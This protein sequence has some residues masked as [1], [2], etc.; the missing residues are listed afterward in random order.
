[1]ETEK[2]NSKI[3]RGPQKMLNSQRNSEQEEKGK[4]IRCPD[5]KI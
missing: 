4:H 5:F 1:M 3:H 2:N